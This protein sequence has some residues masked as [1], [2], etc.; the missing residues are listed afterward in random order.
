MCEIHAGPSDRDLTVVDITNGPFGPYLLDKKEPGLTGS[1]S[2]Q[3]SKLSNLR[4]QRDSRVAWL[5]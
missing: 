5:R 4:N 1:P 2:S 3:L